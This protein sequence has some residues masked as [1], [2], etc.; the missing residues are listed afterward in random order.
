MSKNFQI[1]QLAIDEEALK[2]A[3]NRLRNQIAGVLTW[4]LAILFKLTLL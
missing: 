3:S 1:I 2:K 4:S